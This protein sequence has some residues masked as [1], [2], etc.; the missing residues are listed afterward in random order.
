MCFHLLFKIAKLNLRDRV[1]EWF[2]KLN[3]VSID[4]TKLRTW[5]VQK[6]GNIDANDICIKVNTIK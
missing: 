6:Y 1:K 3:L 5:I 2:R 4:W